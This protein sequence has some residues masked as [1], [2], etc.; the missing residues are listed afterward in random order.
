MYS[1]RQVAAG[2][3]VDVTPLSLLGPTKFAEVLGL[4]FGS[5]L[6]A[7]TSQNGITVPPIP[8]DQILLS[9]ASPEMADGASQFTYPRICLYS[10]GLKNNQIEKF[11]PVSGSV[12]V[13]AEI[14]S[15]GNF[16]TDTDRWIHFYVESFLSVIAKNTG[17][18]GDGLYFPGQFDVQF[19]QPKRGG[20]GFAQMA[21][22]TCTLMVSR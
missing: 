15:S 20:F 1:S 14:W 8:L 5:E 19:Q 16:V 17:D 18:L 7:L 4:Q 6:Q 2:I 22:V 10:G 3:E 21:K 13:V 12:A 9:S 11:R